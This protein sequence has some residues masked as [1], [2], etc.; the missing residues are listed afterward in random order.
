MKAWKRVVMLTNSHKPFDPRVFQKEAR[1]LVHAGYEVTLVVPHTES[2]KSDGVEIV[3]IPV[4]RGGWQK[5][6]VCPWQLLRQALR[7]PRQAIIELHDSEILWI[8]FI[9][10]IF[11]RRVIYDAHEDTPLQISYQHWIPWVLKK[12]YAWMYFLIEKLAGYLFDAIIIAEPVIGKYFPKHK[13]FLV[14]NF[15]IVKVFQQH[16]LPP[17][18]TRNRD[19]VYVGL[20]SKA[21]GLFEMLH[22]AELAHTKTDFRFVLGGK[23]SPPSLEDEVIGKFA[24]EYLSWVE[25]D[26]LMSTLFQARVGIIVPQP[27]E[28]YKTN[29]PVKLFEYW[30][31]GLPVI[32]SRE[33]ESAAFVRESNSGILVDPLNKQEIADAIVYLLE[34][35]Q[36]A[37]AMGKRGQEM[38]FSKYSWEK[39]TPTLLKAVDSVSGFTS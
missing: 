38:I 29:Y 36:E 28:R 5:L 31:A 35:P 27:N 30:S 34:H 26:Q 12:P 13:T 11:G 2:L 9:L 22:G 8:G 37:E 6:I 18:N 1:S 16:T 24:V 10:K 7:Y 4:P 21:R 3:A 20:L 14:R 32:A 39:E 15:P 25:F 19:L 23:F 17:Y 33:G